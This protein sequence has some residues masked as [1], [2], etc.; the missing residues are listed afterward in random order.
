MRPLSYS[1]SL[2]LLLPLSGNPAGAQDAPV[3]PESASSL[4]GKVAVLEI[5]E[6]SLVR[7]DEIAFLHGALERAKSEG[8][9]GVVLVL[10]SPGGFAWE[11]KLFVEQI[12][13]LGIPVVAYVE[14]R[15]LGAG[16]LVAAACEAVY[17]AP[18]TSLGGMVAAIEWRG[19]MAG[20]P[21]RLTEK[22]FEDVIDAI[23][24]VTDK[25]GIPAGMVRAFVDEDE[26]VTAG[27]GTALSGSD[28]FL[29]LGVDEA[30][31]YVPAAKG[32]A[33][34]VEALLGERG[35]EGVALEHFT[36]VPE[37]KRTGSAAVESDEEKAVATGAGGVGDSEGA[38]VEV[39]HTFGQTRLEDYGGKIVVLKVGDET[40]VRSTKFDFMRRVLKKAS[41][42]GAEA[43]ILDMNTPGGLAWDTIDIMMDSLSKVTVPT[44]TYVNPSAMSAGALIAIATDHI[45]MHP[46]S[47][48]GA[49]GVVSAMGEIQGTMKEKITRYVM[50]AARGTATSK[51][52]AQ[53]VAMAF[54]DPETEVVR[55]LA[56]ID[57][58]GR[59][60][61]A[62]QTINP[63]GAMLVLDADQATLRFDGKPVLAEGTAKDI[64][65]LI[66]QA[67]L[68]GDVVEAVPLGFENV[69]DWIVKVAPLLLL[70][71][72]AGAWLEMK[73]P[74]FG[75]PG[76][77]S[78]VCFGLFFF[79]HNLAGKMA[80]YE[81]FGIFLLGVVLIVVEIFLFPG[82]FIFG[83]SGMVLM[84]GSLIFAMVDRS[85][86]RPPGGEGS[87][88]AKYD[89]GRILA[90][91]E[92][93]V[94]NFA[95]A[96]GGAAL[97]VIVL[98]RYLPQTRAM[99]WMM[100]DA[101][102]APGTGMTP[103][104]AVGMTGSTLLGMGGVAQTDLRPAGKVMVGDELLD[105]ITSGEFIGKGRAVR[106]VEQEGMRVVVE[107]V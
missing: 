57:A 28:D 74:G 78:L 53:D 44:F 66:A 80:G 103:A 21:D 93:P 29:R 2:V 79:G 51:G 105:V 68:K 25:R 64:D 107:A 34:S 12:G 17:F 76:F 50:A 45:Y 67:G 99:R 106:V 1:L 73:T 7:R 83:L 24:A 60:G 59:L 32:T 15:A 52:H 95:L 39:E 26:E 35:W 5:G 23:V 22:R 88:G 98:I 31:R 18:G 8:A 63:K 47:T 9:A 90:G 13:A 3:A 62:S 70:L 48:I 19:P 58:T 77:L 96:L 56:L 10:D 92:T 94:F 41:D 84:F 101:A 87:G 38:D 54:I 72:I 71:G 46:P 89:T 42:D 36:F 85:A 100:L 6:F 55:E 37:A 16:A 86:V 82:T 97:L 102:I 43:V 91:L 11:T 33:E 104:V 14:K 49:A 27:D 61:L 4:A 65:D 69:A 40:L 75:I 20:L 81:L 30:M